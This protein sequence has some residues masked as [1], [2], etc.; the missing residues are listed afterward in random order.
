MNVVDT[1]LVLFTSKPKVL[2]IRMLYE[3]TKVL[4]KPK[5]VNANQPF[6]SP[7][8]LSLLPLIIP[9]NFF[10]GKNTISLLF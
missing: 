6:A 1:L 5:F 7:S 4:Y 9:V 10:C 3:D 8:S 2:Q